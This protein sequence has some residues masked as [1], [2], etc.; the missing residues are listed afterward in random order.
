ML[1]DS[2]GKPVSLQVENAYNQEQYDIILM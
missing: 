2:I 1:S